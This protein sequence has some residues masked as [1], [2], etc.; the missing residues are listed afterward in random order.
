MIISPSCRIICAT[1]KT[2]RSS[3]GLVTRIL[4][5]VAD[6]QLS[7]FRLRRGKYSHKS[8]SHL[9]QATQS[10]V[11]TSLRVKR[12]LTYPFPLG[13]TRTCSC[14]LISPGLTQLRLIANVF[15]LFFFIL[16]LSLLSGKDRSLWTSLLH[17]S[18]RRLTCWSGCWPRR[19]HRRR[20]RP[21]PHQAGGGGEEG[22]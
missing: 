4:V 15:F 11:F 8:S 3:G 20:I 5:L 18:T 17:S 21:C 19:G 10:N 2:T 13:L 6:S 1:C 14:N 9:S 22:P 12:P 16:P 7:R